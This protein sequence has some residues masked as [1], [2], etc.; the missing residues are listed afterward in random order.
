MKYCF[1][2]TPGGDYQAPMG[3]GD[4]APMSDQT[5]PDSGSTKTFKK[6]SIEMA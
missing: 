2:E 5:I 4:D 3:G 1:D 6:I